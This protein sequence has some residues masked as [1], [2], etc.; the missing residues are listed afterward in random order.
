MFRVGKFEFVQP[1]I[2]FF[3]SIL[4]VEISINLQ[5]TSCVEKC[6]WKCDHGIG[7]CPLVCGA[8]CSR[9][10]CNMVSILEI[11]ACIVYKNLSHKLVTAK[12]CTKSLKCGH[13]C[14]SLCGE[15]CPSASFCQVCGQKK[16]EIVDMICLSAFGDH[17]VSTDPVICLPCGHF[18]AM[19]TLDGHLAIDSAY[20]ID[21][22]GNFRALRSLYSSDITEKSKG[23]PDCRAPIHSIN[24]YGRILKF[25]ELRSLERKH[26]MS[27]DRSL[28][29]LNSGS[30]ERNL[31][32]ISILQDLEDQI[33]QSPMKQVWEA[34]RGDLDVEVPKPP[35][36]QYLRIIEMLS[37][38]FTT[39]IEQDG[40]E[41]YKLAVTTFERGI[42]LAG[43]SAS[44]TTNGRLRLMLASMLVT[45]TPFS[46]LFKAE[47]Q[48]LL[49]WIFDQDHMP[50][51]TKEKATNL[52]DGIQSKVSR[53]VVAE[54][55]AAMNSVG[56]G[57]DYGGSW[58]S[59]WYECPN[60]HPFF[61]GDCGGAMEVA[62]CVECNEEVGGRG[63][64]LLRSN[65][66][67]GGVVGDI[68]RGL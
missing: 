64:A 38:A 48:G 61:I 25:S 34:S 68:M 31:N 40:D 26:M 4:I 62:R 9:L 11:N 19:S 7:Q 5:C 43:E 57:Y 53:K 51:D 10:P 17:D 21:V 50:S 35:T 6:D 1:T 36:T 32:T 30:M 49:Q 46:P 23:C 45:W 60:G 29:I 56:A 55:V 27:I 39:K 20:D 54:V 67:V 28:K 24:R 63:H 65:R 2:F 18:Y 13:Q 3:G 14:P 22:D 59:H 15:V 41:Y 52:L 58:A 16:S 47:I 44:H 66:T 8:P 42:T 37:A 12:R 33:K